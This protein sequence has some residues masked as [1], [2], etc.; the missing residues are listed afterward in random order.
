[1]LVTPSH[2]VL[3]ELQIGC[4]KLCCSIIADTHFALRRFKL[5]IM[6]RGT[7]LAVGYKNRRIKTCAEGNH[8][9]VRIALLHKRELT[10]AEIQQ[11]PYKSLHTACGTGPQKRYALAILLSLRIGE[12]TRF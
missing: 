1:M 11:E 5:G 3:S 6:C 9:C 7:N 12:H 4:A 2:L 10:V 8:S